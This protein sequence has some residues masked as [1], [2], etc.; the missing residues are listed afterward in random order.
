MVSQRCNNLVNGVT[1]KHQRH[2]DS[3]I[4][5]FQVLSSPTQHLPLLPTASHTCFSLKQ[6]RQCFQ[7]VC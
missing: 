7:P 4:M 5:T 1:A 3:S 2:Y 6:V